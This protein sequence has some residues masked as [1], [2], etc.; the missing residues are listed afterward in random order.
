MASKD[1]IT[2]I[3]M[4][5]VHEELLERAGTDVYQLLEYEKWKR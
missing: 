3:Q 4:H 5:R 2:G 1:L